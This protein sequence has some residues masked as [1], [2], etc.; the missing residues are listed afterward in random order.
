MTLE[1]TE[2]CKGDTLALLL[3]YAAFMNK[4]LVCLAGTVS[5]RITQLS[6]IF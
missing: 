2:W 1:E 3:E 6:L 5:V 4:H